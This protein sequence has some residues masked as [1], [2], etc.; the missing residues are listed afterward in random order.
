MW[1]KW[2]NMVKIQYLKHIYNFKDINLTYK[3]NAL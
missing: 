3:N 1:L 2:L